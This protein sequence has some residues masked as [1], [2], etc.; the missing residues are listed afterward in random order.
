MMMGYFGQ[1]KKYTNIIITGCL[2]DCSRCHEAEERCISWEEAG[3]MQG[4]GESHLVPWSYK[5]YQEWQQ[6]LIWNCNKLVLAK[7]TLMPKSV[8]L[9]LVPLSF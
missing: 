1:E 9:K 3:I 2:Q 8:V 6:Y 4:D 7:T 5:E